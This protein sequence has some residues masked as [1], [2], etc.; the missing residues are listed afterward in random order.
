MRNSLYLAAAAAVGPMLALASPAHAGLQFF[1]EV[2]PGGPPA[3]V[4]CPGAGSPSPCDYNGA[5]TSLTLNPIPFT[6]N[7]VVITG[8]LETAS[9]V[10]GAPGIDSLASSSLAVLNTTDTVKTVTVVISDTDYTAPVANVQLSGS[11]TFQATVGSTLTYEW[12][13][14][15]L[16]TQGADPTGST[17]PGTPLHS[18]TTTATG[19]VQSFATNFS[20]PFSATAPFSMTEEVVYTLQ[21]EGELL[22]RGTTMVASGVPEPSTWV[23]MALGFAGLGFLGH[24]SS[25]TKIAM[26]D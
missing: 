25:R 9:G 22:S 21:P 5:G 7:G 18:F 3:S 6:L 17:P 12:F 23:M 10:P 2:T 26:I 19:L 1:L 8:A 4:D 24:R 20:T 16:N 11:G 14:D 15:P 13:A